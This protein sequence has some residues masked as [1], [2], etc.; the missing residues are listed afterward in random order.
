M[1]AK[2]NETITFEFK[3]EQIRMF[4]VDYARVSMVELNIK[5]EFFDEYNI[6]EDIVCNVDSH[7]LNRVVKK[8]S[9]K[10]IEMIPQ[11]E[12]LILKNSK[13][14]FELT[15]FEKSLSDKQTPVFDAPCVFNVSADEFFDNVAEYMVFD[16]VCEFS[17]KEEKISLTTK[18][19]KV[20]G[21]TLL[22]SDIIKSSSEEPA[23]YDG[24]YINMVSDI[25]NIFK[26]FK[27]HFGSA[28][29]CKLEQ[30]D[31][32]LNFT[33]VLAARVVE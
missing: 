14:N 24:N 23:F 15:L 17:T 19:T 18:G 16:S 6:T 10:E 11:R 25:K 26:N 29:P 7:D 2:Y 33:W 27:F 30:S 21:Y 5:K 1:M 28:F 22:D 20:K 9:K 31:N 12:N 32:E 8:V 13:D 3:T 4:I